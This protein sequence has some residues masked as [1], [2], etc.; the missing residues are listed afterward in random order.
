MSAVLPRFSTFASVVLTDEGPP[1]PT[2]KVDVRKPFTGHGQ[3]LPPLAD[4]TRSYSGPYIWLPGSKELHEGHRKYVNL[5]NGFPSSLRTARIVEDID[6]VPY[7]EGIMGPE[8]ELNANARNSKFVYDRNFLLQFMSICKEKP[9]QLPPL[10]TIG[11]EPVD[12]QFYMSR[13]ESGRHRITS[14]MGS[15][16]RHSGSIG[17]AIR[18]TA[19]TAEKEKEE[20]EV[21]ESPAKLLLK[22]KKEALSINTGPSPEARKQRPGPLAFSYGKKDSPP[23][24]PSALATA[25]IIEDIG[26][27]AYPKGIQSPKIELNVNA[28]DSKF[29]YDR[30]FLLQFM[31]ICKEKPDQLLPLDAIGLEPVDQQFSMS[32]GG[33]GRHRTTSMMGPPGLRS[34]SIGLGIGNFGKPG[35]P[36]GSGFSIGNFATLRATGDGW[37]VAGGEGGGRATP[38][39]PPKAGDLSNFGKI[40]KTAPMT[41]GPTSVF[42]KGKD[43]GKPRA[44]STLSRSSSSSNMFSMLSQNPEIAVEAANSKSSRPPSQRT[45]VDL[46]PGSAPEAPLQRKKLQLPRP[47]RSDDSITLRRVLTM[48]EAEATKKV[49]E[50]SNGFFAVRNLDEAENYFEKLTPENH[51]RLVDELANT[52][53]FARAVEKELCS[54]AA[55]EEGFMPITKILDDIAIDV[56]KAFDLMAM[57]M[58]GAGFDEV[59]RRR[60]AGKSTEDY[61]LF[62]LLI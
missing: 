40:N 25:R 4:K 33:S 50:V 16:G 22:K 36:G 28:K 23:S 31:S 62:A 53:I 38:R 9:E 24:F 57:M 15:P 11:L 3:S 35:T 29:K 5:P 45:S 7:P 1:V 59:T 10:A 56:P 52:A 14:M 27:V 61:R 8:W 20:G 18:Q 54:Q 30:D 37:T 12:K 60:I 39:P 44:E 32:R 13:G 43:G 21:V 17:L 51:F 6:K 2:R 46:S 34:S 47:K 19:A 42:A 58:K 48:S 41:F 26:Q 55:F 49:G